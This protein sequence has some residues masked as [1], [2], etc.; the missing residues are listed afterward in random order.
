[1]P[2]VRNDFPTCDHYPIQFL[3]ANDLMTHD[4]KKEITFRN[5]KN[6]NTT[7][8]KSDIKKI[9]ASDS[10]WMGT[11]PQSINAFNKACTNSLNKHAPLHTKTIRDLKTAPWFDSEYKQLRL[12]RRQA[13]KQWYKHNLDSDKAIFKKLRLQCINMAKSKESEYYKSHFQKYSNSQKSLYQF[14]NLFLDRSPA[15]TLPPTESILSSVKK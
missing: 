10:E 3:L 12:K 1:M 6:I 7:D 13:E 9:L 11:F 4:G 8:F 15:L 2:A 14:A 5:I